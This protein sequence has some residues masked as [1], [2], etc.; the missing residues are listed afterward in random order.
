MLKYTTRCPSC[1]VAF[2][3]TSTQL[4]AAKGKVRCGLCQTIFNANEEIVD[5]DDDI[6]IYDEMPP[7]VGDTAAGEETAQPTVSELEKT[8]SVAQEEAKSTTEQEQVSEA[9]P[10]PPPSRF[11]SEPEFPIIAPPSKIR[12]RQGLWLLLCIMACLALAGQY[13]HF[14]A[15]TIAR[16]PSYLPWIQ[17]FCQFTGCVIDLRDISRITT[18]NLLIQSHPKIVNALKVNVTLQNNAPFQ[19][20]FPE[21]VLVF[22]DI[23]GKTVASRSLRP[24]E[25]LRGDL[26]DLS[27]MPAGQPVHLELEILDP[28]SSAQSYRLFLE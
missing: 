16:N 17:R 10:L 6:L 8:S 5:D 23:N 25:Y 4:Q 7:L 3:V 9:P 24:S 18:T 1:H 27:L 21:L 2:P 26:A 13:L 19:Q 22:E 28:G 14:S 12:S 20:P 11:H 15:N